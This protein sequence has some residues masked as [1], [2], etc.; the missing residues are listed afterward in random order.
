MKILASGGSK[1]SINPSSPDPDVNR[2]MSTSSLPDYDCSLASVNCDATNFSNNFGGAKKKYSTTDVNL[3]KWSSIDLTSSNSNSRHN[4][5]SS[6]NRMSGDFERQQ[7]LHEKM[8]LNKYIW[9]TL[10]FIFMMAFVAT[11]ICV[12]GFAYI[13]YYD[14]KFFNSR[15]HD[16]K[17]FFR[18]SEQHSSSPIYLDSHDYNSDYWLFDM[19]FFI[20]T[21]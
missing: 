9:Y 13:K 7:E 15:F 16:R 3:K 20:T 4:S 10:I 17:M 19:T 1:T 2:Q 12:L 8:I 18:S 11:V 5:L 14:E 21:I 6:N